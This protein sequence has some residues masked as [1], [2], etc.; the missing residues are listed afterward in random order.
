MAFR[1]NKVQQA[2]TARELLA[3]PVGFTASV[4]EDPRGRTWQDRVN[5]V[6]RSN[7]TILRT[8][9]MAVLSASGRPLPA[10]ADR[11]TLAITDAKVHNLKFPTYDRA[12]RILLG[13]PSPLAIQQ[14]RKEAKARV[15]RGRTSSGPREASP[16]DGRKTGGLSPMFEQ[17]PSGGV[18]HRTAVCAICHGARAAVRAQMRTLGLTASAAA[19]E[20]GVVSLVTRAL[21]P[22][23]PSL[24]ATGIVSRIEYEASFPATRR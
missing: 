1:K 20:P 22:H 13:D 3:E 4:E 11:W 2:E 19:L 18:L 24:A 14:L 17:R 23:A 6:A 15:D 12:T 10:G 9:G 16:V 21:A 5:W 8:F 7:P